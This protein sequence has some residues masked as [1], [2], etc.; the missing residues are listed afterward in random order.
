MELVSTC[1][2]LEHLEKMTETLR[3]VNQES[4]GASALTL[5]K[6]ISPLEYPRNIKTLPNHPDQR[7][8]EGTPQN[9]R[10]VR[11]LGQP[12]GEQAERAVPR[13]KGRPSGPGQLPVWPPLLPGLECP[14]LSSEGWTLMRMLMRTNI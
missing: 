1:F 12:Q 7:G 2:G 4:L 9:T 10:C 6:S 3:A 5:K 8:L 11:S 13:E 14:R